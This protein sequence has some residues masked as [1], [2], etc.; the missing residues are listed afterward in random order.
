MWTEERLNEMLTTPS[1]ALVEDIKKINGDIMILGAGG[2]MGPSMALLIRN[3][4]IKAG[5]QK[6][7]IAVSRF[8]DPVAKNYLAIIKLK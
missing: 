4:I 6:K 5:I 1:D 7:V 2:K 8:S 3:A